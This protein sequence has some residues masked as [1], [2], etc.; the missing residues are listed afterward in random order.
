MPTMTRVH[1]LLDIRTRIATAFLMALAVLAGIAAIGLH[2][3]SHINE[4][5]RSIVENNI[6]KI[7][8]ATAMQNALRERALSMHALS[9]LTDP[10]DK[11]EEV[12]RFNA[13]GSDYVRAR[14]QLEGMPLSAEELSILDRIRALTRAAQPEVQGVV[15]MAMSG[16]D[17]DVFE[18]IRNVAVPRQRMIAE[19]VNALIQ[20]QKGQTAASVKSTETSYGELRSLMLLLG[21]LALGSG[22][23]ITFFVNRQAQLAIKALHDPLTGL[24]NRRFLQDRLEHAIE[25]SKRSQKPFGVALM[26]LNRFKEVNDTLG[27][28]VGDE[29]LRIVAARLRQGVRANDTVARMGGDEFVVLFNDLGAEDAPALC[30]H[31]LA[32]LG[33][34]FV[35]GGHTIDLSASI[36]MSL[37]PAH[38]SDPGSLLRLADI[39]M[40]SAKRSGRGHA[41][42]AP[43]QE[44]VSL[45]DLSLNSALRESIQT[46]RLRL[47]YQPKICHVRQRVVGL[48]ALVRWNHP[49]RGL[50]T[51]ES[52]I[53]HAEEAG[54]IDLLTHWVLKTALAQLAVLRAEG[55]ALGMAINLSAKCLCAEEL[56]E[57]ITEL[58]DRSGLEAGLLTLEVTESAIMAND[59]E[60]LANLARL[61]EMGV[62][63]AIDD[64]GTGYSSLAHLR[65]LPA[66]E[67]KIDKSFVMDMATNKSDAVIVRS[68]IELA[69]NLGLQVTAEGVETEGAWHA[70]AELGCDQSQGFHMSPPLPETELLD[71]LR[72]SPWA[73]RM[74]SQRTPGPVPGATFRRR[75]SK[76]ASERKKPDGEPSGLNRTNYWHGEEKVG[77]RSLMPTG[78]PE[79]VSRVRCVGSGDGAATAM[80]FHAGLGALQGGLQVGNTSLGT[81]PHGCQRAAQQLAQIRTALELCATDVVFNGDKVFVFH[82]ALLQDGWDLPIRIANRHA[83]MHKEEDR[84]FE[85]RF[86]IVCLDS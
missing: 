41:L 28:D 34:Q 7:E 2:Y 39:A 40:Y 51:P 72:L 62:M 26:D 6:V 25:A 67:I 64:F 54:L 9:V 5:L 48:E 4:N 53:P 21:T 16:R 18:R 66:H 82:G 44:L 38:A 61:D 85:T 43:Q 29:L 83:A 81:L 12:L 8:L 65:R 86:P 49:Q 33:S 42:Y 17:H 11:D 46:G 80:L 63:I 1:K 24:P 68:M 27:H 73:A 58:L 76:P 36:G 32:V 52:F 13:L 35:W 22:F 79:S 69:H 77:C 50:L 60:V 55:H 30:D 70:L 78:S 45:G 59:P 31:L 47:H 23:A 74:H 56:T 57:R 10:F 20:V 75:A 19:Q 71:W 14:Q 37:Y 3:I 15:D 84:A